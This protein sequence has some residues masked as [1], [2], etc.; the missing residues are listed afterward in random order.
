MIEPVQPIPDNP[1]S[2]SS[3]AK[4]HSY[5]RKVLASDRLQGAWNIQRQMITLFNKG[6][7]HVA[8]KLKVDAEFVTQLVRFHEYAHALFHLGVDQQT[9][10]ALAQAYLE[11]NPARIPLLC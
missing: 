2:L 10:A 4:H 1:N 5:R 7:Q 9:N 3:V 8:A 6:I 11:N